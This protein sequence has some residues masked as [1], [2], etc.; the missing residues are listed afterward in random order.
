[1]SK[2]TTAMV[3]RIVVSFYVVY[4]GYKVLS[5]VLSGGS[6]IPLWGAWLVFLGFTAAA[7][8]FCVFALVKFLKARKAAEICESGQSGDDDSNSK[9]DAERR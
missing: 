5:G 8:Y 4:L 6:P 3:L 2:A 9:S 1:M 7:I